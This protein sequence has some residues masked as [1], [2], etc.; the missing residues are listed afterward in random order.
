M[1]FSSAC[2]FLAKRENVLSIYRFVVTF[3]IVD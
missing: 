3:E 1:L 2:G